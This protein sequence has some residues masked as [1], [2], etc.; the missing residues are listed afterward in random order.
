MDLKLVQKNFKGF[1]KSYHHIKQA[2]QSVG[3]SVSYAL[4]AFVAI[5]VCLIID[6]FFNIPLPL[7]LCILVIFIFGL[8]SLII[9]LIYLW[10]Q[11]LQYLELAKECEEELLIGGEPLQTACASLNEPNDQLQRWDLVYREL[12]EVL[13]QSKKLRKVYLPVRKIAA[14]FLAFCFFTILLIKTP[15]I[16]SR[17][18]QRFLAPNASNGTL[19][20]TILELSKD[21]IQYD[22]ESGQAVIKG[23]ILQGTSDKAT[24]YL[25]LEEAGKAAFRVPGY[26]DD[27]DISFTYLIPSTN[28][29]AQIYYEKERSEKKI[30][31]P[32]DLP[33]IQYFTRKITPLAYLNSSVEK[34]KELTA[35][36][37]VYAGSTVSYEVHT[38][39]SVR[40]IRVK[41]QDKTILA[42]KSL[43][44]SSYAFELKPFK[45]E[46]FEIL[47]DAVDGSTR[48]FFYQG[49][50]KPD[51]PPEV[52][53]RTFPLVSVTSSG[54][55][56]NVN[57]ESIDDL[58]IKSQ[59][60]QVEDASG[61]K[62]FIQELNSQVQAYDFEVPSFSGRSHWFHA[63]VTAIDF[64]NQESSPLVF[65]FWNLNDPSLQ[66]RTQKQNELAQAIKQTRF[67]LSELSNARNTLSNSNEGSFEEKQYLSLIRSFTATSNQLLVGS[68]LSLD[69]GDIE[70]WQRV[71]GQIAC[72]LIN[73]GVL[74]S[75]LKS[76]SYVEQEE[77]R[78]ASLLE[79]L[80]KLYE[81]K[82]IWVHQRLLYHLIKDL[83]LKTRL[84]PTLLEYYY[85][86]LSSQLSKAPNKTIK[87]SKMI[88]QNQLLQYAKAQQ[89]EYAK[90]GEQKL[91]ESLYSDIGGPKN[92]KQVSV[93]QT[94]SPYAIEQVSF[95]L[96]K[97]SPKIQIML[98]YVDT[99]FIQTFLQVKWE[100]FKSP[101][102]IDHQLNRVNYRQ[103]LGEL[104]RTSSEERFT[105]F[106]SSFEEVLENNNKEEL[107][108]FKEALN[109]L[110]VRE[111]KALLLAWASHLPM[112]YWESSLQRFNALLDLKLGSNGL[113]LSTMQSYTRLL[114]I[115]TERPYK[116]SFKSFPYLAGR[117]TDN[118]IKD[119][120]LA[121][122]L[123]LFP[124]S[125][126]SRKPEA[127]NKDRQ[128]IDHNFLRW[129][130]LYIWDN[131]ITEWVEP[132]LNFIVEYIKEPQKTDWS[133]E[134]RWL[135]TKEKF[136]ETYKYDLG[137][138]QIILVE[139]QNLLHSIQQK[140]MNMQF[141]NSANNEFFWQSDMNSKIYEIP[142][143][144][145][146]S[147]PNRIFSNWLNQ[148]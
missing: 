77:K 46:H 75:K 105:K 55:I 34:S 18:G 22:L 41:Y 116:I 142:L 120:K 5:Y 147:Y 71:C 125:T 61:Q 137:T 118:I 52:N 85:F 144:E 30:F 56:V 48:S 27:T 128:N 63:K 15:A 101:P 50:I 121:E 31:I 104:Y 95:N 19:G 114:E 139:M 23:K 102:S 111:K 135:T 76:Q 20:S 82:Q 64:A 74:Q 69:L 140:N 25:Y 9:Q 79:E 93:N 60:I 86:I 72:E 32:P 49:K 91:T 148:E 28:Y 62:L 66:T 112:R 90:H 98:E 94:V 97:Y 108:A 92:F 59:K 132:Y 88:Q 124:K 117:S 54:N 113:S 134:L 21:H 81:S 7:R 3:L 14:L 44:S 13:E 11:P 45:S 83:D 24:Y 126:I 133:S 115:G 146:Y 67:L 36:F 4:I 136:Q 6:Y 39:N 38:T 29:S 40:G 100:S 119:L 51:F 12:E 123:V 42:S 78:L 84:S 53:E 58:G 73:E 2:E 26:L 65:S 129:L 1:L 37:E 68:S 122:I 107:I 141:H 33:K 99:I 130:N 138:R 57:W 43:N 145:D 35:D 106:L 16:I 89:I 70:R 80:L 127:F 143:G 10:S 131:Q 109:E 17:F 8:L 87:S 110:V 103:Q 47:I 96:L